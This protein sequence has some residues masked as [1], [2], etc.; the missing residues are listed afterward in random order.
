MPKGTPNVSAAV[1]AARQR[2]ASTASGTASRT[3]WFID[4]VS[5]TIRLTME[6]RVALATDYVFNKTVKNIRTPVI[7]VTTKRGTRVTGRSKAGEY[8]RAD[9]TQLMKTLFKHVINV[10]GSSSGYVGTPLDYGVI[11]EL[12]MNRSYLVRTLN[13]SMGQVKRILTGP[14]K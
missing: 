7:K 5:N 11:L 10:R 12:R 13:E 3:E 4:K 8:P 9:T 1:S 6:Q 14:I 2:R